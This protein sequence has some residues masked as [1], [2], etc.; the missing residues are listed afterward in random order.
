MRGDLE[1]V[2]YVLGLRRSGAEF[3]GPCPLCGGTDRFHIRQGRQHD[4][5]VH[6]RYG[7]R[8]QDIA[9]HL[10]HIGVI[11]D[12]RERWATIEEDSREIEAL[13]RAFIADIERGNQPSS[14]QKSDA[15]QAVYKLTGFRPEQFVE[16]YLWRE[17]FFGNLE[18]PH[19]FYGK[20]SF[21]EFKEIHAA[22][23]GR[24]WM[25]RGCAWMISKH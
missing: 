25:L 2:A 10:L 7:C 15:R 19:V 3:K 5:I 6:C 13:L 4:L 9:R 21:E 18:A 24:E 11:E 23:S 17:V 20:K 22:L 14:R 12:D 8:F 1:T 16:M